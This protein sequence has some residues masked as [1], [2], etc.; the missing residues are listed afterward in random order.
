MNS[1]YSLTVEEIRRSSGKAI[2]VVEH[3]IDLYYHMALSMYEAIEDR[4]AAGEASTCILPVG[5]VF[6]YRR[7]IQLLKRRPLDL[8]RLFIFFMDEYVGEDGKWIDRTS[9]LSFRGFIQR[10]LTDPMPPEMGLQKNHI[11]FPEPGKTEEYDERID[12]LGGIMFCHAGVGIVGHLAFNE[13]IDER[14]ITAEAFADLP[15][16]VVTLTPQTI[17]INADTALRGAVEEIPKSAATVGMRQILGA[18][19]LRIYFN[20]AWQNAVWRKALMLDPTSEFPAT[21]ARNH[22]DVRYIMTE[23]VAAPPEFALK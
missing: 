3:D 21:L 5:P 19:T 1:I 20:R 7:F 13:P 8:S 14:E 16:R 12:D 15:S 10:E 11:F 2:E 23:S 22:P 6:Q 18:Q 9:P 4:N 17:T